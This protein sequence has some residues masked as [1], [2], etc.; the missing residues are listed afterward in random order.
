MIGSFI[1]IINNSRN[2]IIQDSPQTRCY[3]N[4]SGIEEMDLCRPHL[5][6]QLALQIS[7]LLDH[8]EGIVHTHISWPGN[9]EKLHYEALI[10]QIALYRPAD[11]SWLAH[12]NSNSHRSFRG[13]LRQ[14]LQL[15]VILPALHP[16]RHRRKRRR[17]PVT[18]P[19]TADAFASQ[20]KKPSQNIGAPSY[21]IMN[22]PQA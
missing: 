1:I 3:G 4:R 5:G 14:Q 13:L 12:P 15:A 10:F 18:R 17:S 20:K 6:G 16:Q 19:T 2:P 9:G 7:K 11:I 8:L 22:L 21:Y